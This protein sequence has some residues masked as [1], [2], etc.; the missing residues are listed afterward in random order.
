MSLEKLKPPFED[1]RRPIRLVQEYLLGKSRPTCLNS[2]QM[3]VYWS[4]WWAHVN[5]WDWEKKD[6]V[7]V[8]WLELKPDWAHLVLEDL[9]S[10]IEALRKHL[11]KVTPPTKRYAANCG[12]AITK[13]LIHHG[14]SLAELWIGHY[15]VF[16][17][18]WIFLGR[19]AKCGPRGRSTR[20]G[21]SGGAQ[22][23]GAQLGGA[24]STEHTSSNGRTSIGEEQG[25]R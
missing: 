18:S 22:L 15:K 4:Y 7:E 3:W 10:E 17:P 1:L 19:I 23:G 25:S 5:G 11:T 20:G 2:K 9:S 21:Q 12:S 24:H 6:G 8:E 14:Y 13:F 16:D